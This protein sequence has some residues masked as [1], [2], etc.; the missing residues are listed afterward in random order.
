MRFPTRALLVLV[1]VLLPILAA[2]PHAAADEWGDAKKAFR[3]AQKSEE[4]AVRRDAYMD[5]LNFDSK[6]SAAEALAAMLK[7]KKRSDASPA[8]LLAGVQTL[9][10]LMSDG[11]KGVILDAVKKGR[12]DKRLLALLALADRPTGGGEDLLLEV[13]QSKEEPLI[14]QAAVAL[15]RRK[16]QAAVPHL[17]KLLES[18]TWQ[19]RAAA[20]RA[21]ELAA[22][23]AKLDP[24]TAELVLPPLPTWMSGELPR[25]LGALASSLETARGSSRRNIIS[26]LKRLS[27]QDYG[28]DVE[29]W[30]RLA[31]GEDPETIRPK[32][33]KVPYIF[34]IPIFGERVILIIDISTCTDDT[35]PFQDIDRLKEVCSIPHARPVAWYEVRTTK[36]FFAAHAKRLIK[37]LPSRGQ[38][39]EVIAVF[40]KVEPLFEKL[41]PCNSGTKRTARTFIDEFSVQNGPNHFE[42]L[43]LALDVSGAKDKIAWSLGPDEVILMTCAIPWAPSDPNAMVG[44][45]EVGQAIGLKAR[46]RMVPVHSIGVGPHPWEMMQILSTQTGGRYVDLSK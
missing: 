14:A 15:G 33:I 6:E 22:G 2:A 38:K 28:Y 41:A 4:Q 27:E 32:P 36:Q 25:Y 3:R 40:G 24:K 43:T 17:L 13:L 19:L 16:S 44:Q 9:A 8:A 29:A 34:G 26:A 42:G 30:K 37:D 45:T 12:G 5:L 1:C 11:A 18:D 10:S 23:E 20:A 35:H 46:L 39:F 21:L 31:G 7:E